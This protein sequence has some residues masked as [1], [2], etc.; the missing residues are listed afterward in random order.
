MSSYSCIYDNSNEHQMKIILKEYISN[1]NI[2]FNNDENNK[3]VSIDIDFINNLMNDFYIKKKKENKIN[4]NIQIDNDYEIYDNKNE[5]KNIIFNEF[6]LEQDIPKYEEKEY[7]C[8]N[9]FNN[10]PFNFYYTNS[11]VLLF[12]NFT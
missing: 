4:L 11:L 6:Y 2:D 8:D 12:T 3:C 10:C 9:D 5:N 7:Y 1:E